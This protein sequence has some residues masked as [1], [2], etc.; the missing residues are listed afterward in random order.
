MS[1]NTGAQN[2]QF[3]PTVS[4]VR[5]IPWS[6]PPPQLPLPPYDPAPVLNMPLSELRPFPTY[7]PRCSP[8]PVQE[9]RPILN[10]RI[11]DLRTR[12][13]PLALHPRNPPPRG[14]VFIEPLI[15]A[16]SGRKTAN[17]FRDATT[18][19]L[20]TFESLISPSSSGL[21]S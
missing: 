16:H 15:V 8:A 18:D 7:R 20:R 3:G 2:H 11:P 19:I 1:S 14:L 9:L 10:A 13:G 17:I 4:G 12:T 21:N 6:P 5:F